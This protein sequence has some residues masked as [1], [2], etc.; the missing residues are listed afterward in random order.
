MRRSDTDDNGERKVNSNRRWLLSVLGT[1]GI[2]GLAGCGGDGDS[3]DT[4]G[5]GGMTNTETGG[6]GGM[7]NT[8]T[9]T[10]TEVTT[11]TEG[12]GGLGPNPE[13]IF[14]FGEDLTVSPSTEEITS[15]FRNPY[16]GATL[17]SGT[18]EVTAGEGDNAPPDGWSLEAN[19]ATE[20]DTLE[21]GG[22]KQ[23][24]WSVSVPGE[25][26]EFPLTIA[27]TY[28]S[29]G[30]TYEV[31]T[32]VTME[33]GPAEPAPGF[34]GVPTDPD[35]ATAVTIIRGGIQLTPLQL[36]GGGDAWMVYHPQGTDN[37]QAA[38]FGWAGNY[39]DGEWHHVLAS[40]DSNDGLRGYIDGTLVA[41]DTEGGELK[42][43]Q[44]TLSIAG[45][46]TTSPVLELYQGDL[47]EFG[48]Y[49]TALSQSQAQSL[50]NGETVAE[51]SLVS[52]WTFDE[53][54]FSRVM[55]EIG[56]NTMY[57]ANSPEQVSGEVGQAVAFDGQETFG[58]ILNSDSLNLTEQQS[59]SFWVKTTQS[60]Q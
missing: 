10:E 54:V 34:V 50:A 1:A 37:F 47:D 53:V 32:T 40:Y 57:L 38:Q 14:S 18:V 52:K 30:E 31:E 20:F 27:T 5:N 2:T 24:T 12:G 17:N 51:D 60:V 22:S 39:D 13:Q 55:D 6:N 28:S 21:S 56:D 19:A 49:D 29:G 7:T 42:P 11:T 59:M 3:T 33:I 23:I 16:L 8:P 45:N 26:A 15:A 58:G 25:R 46:V 44:K 4:G 41:E 43:K 35:G 9:A 48:V 36:I